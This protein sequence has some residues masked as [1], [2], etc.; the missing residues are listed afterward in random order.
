MACTSPLYRVDAEKP[1]FLRLPDYF[2]KK[3]RNK[4]VFL[5]SSD[6]DYL[7]NVHHFPADF[8][9]VLP[10]GQC[11]SCRLG[12]AKSWAIRCMLEAQYHE[13]NYFITL[14]YN[15]RHLPRGEFLTLSGDILDTSLRR[16][17][18][19]DFIKRYREYE[20]STFGNDGI[21]VF[22]CGEYG[23]LNDRPHYH[24]LLFGVTP[25]EDRF[26]WRK[27]DNF[28]YYRSPLLEGL[29]STPLSLSGFSFS[30]PIG[31]IE[32]SPL[33]FDTCA[34]TARYCL[35]KITGKPKK[36]FLDYYATLDNPPPVRTEPFLGM[37]RRPGLGAQY[38]HDHKEDIYLSD[39]VLYQK[40]FQVFSSKPP[41]YFDK[42][43]D[44]D[45][46][47]EMAELKE[48]RRSLAI[49]SKS[50]LDFLGS[51]TD[52]FSS[53]NYLSSDQVKRK[54]RFI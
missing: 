29:W 47:E 26:I 10:C 22:Y 14:T 42:L 45:N 18:L 38:Y 11:I 52:Y 7:I 32:F 33:S 2:Q 44:I 54:R 49:A 16:K 50:A 12:Y 20:R 15:D 9:Q 1:G 51:E 35:K 4:G 48:E 24:L 53:R 36:E 5:S 28:S 23:D 31:H 27:K 17:D 37:S 21:K 6:R 34:Y 8:I 43:F 13:H 3:V 19:T 41:R 40:D 46:P 30:V 39:E 25:L